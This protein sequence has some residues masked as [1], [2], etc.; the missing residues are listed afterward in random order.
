MN[1][2]F[3]LFAVAALAAGAA[4]CAVSAHAQSAT[5]WPTK[6]IRYIVPF[7]PG[8]PGD[9]TGRMVAQKLSEMWGQQ[10]VVDNK[11]G[12]NTVIGAVE[13]ARAAPDGYTLFQPMNSTLTI[14][15][16]AMSKMPYD[17]VRDYTHI[18]VIAAV[19]LL[20]MAN[21]TLP[22][23]N[24][25]ELIAYAKANPGKVTVG[26]GNIG[27]QL[28]VERFVRDSGAKVTYVP[29]KSGA[30]V[31]KA[32]LSG[33]IQVGFDGVPAYPAFIKSGRLRALATN[34]PKRIALLPDVPSL[35]ESG[36]QHSEAPIWHALVAPA[37]LAPE[38][39]AKIARD[40][41]AVLAMPDIKERMG[42]LG[43]EPS[44]M[45]ADGFVNLIRTESATNGPIVKDLGIKME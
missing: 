25:K 45:N 36:L 31:T 41:Q 9:V 33:E 15:Q 44:W 42:S 5:T 30:D 32:L 35:T 8:G 12:G 40:V 6:P 43:L 27:Q 39:R 16:F 29:Y 18:G 4:F 19:P 1:S 34:S 13:A 38:I 14:N 26:G 11:A 21:D 24:I 23:K 3:R 37:G 20:V 2:K 10:V 28:A 17:S 7:A 22:A